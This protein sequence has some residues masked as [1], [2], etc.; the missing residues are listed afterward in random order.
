MKITITSFSDL[1]IDN[2][3]HLLYKGITIDRWWGKTLYHYDNQKNTL[4]C[5]HFSLFGLLGQ[6]FG[7]KKHYNN[8][9]LT[10][11]L[12]KNIT[13]IKNKN[14]ESITKNEALKA[15]SNLQTARNKY[16]I[17]TSGPDMKRLIPG[18]KHEMNQQY[19]KGGLHPDDHDREGHTVLMKACKF[20]D[21]DLATK[22]LEDGANINAKETRYGYSAIHYAIGSKNI[23]LVKLLIRKG[24]DLSSEDRHNRSNGFDKLLLHYLVIA[25]SS[26]VKDEEKEEWFLLLNETLKA[27]PES[28]KNK[29]LNSL[30]SQACAFANKKVVEML[31]A[32][33]AE[34]NPKEPHRTLPILTAI[35][36]GNIK[37]IEWLIGKGASLKF[38]RTKREDS[39]INLAIDKFGVK[40]EA[41]CIQLLE[42][43]VKNGENI[44]EKA[45]ENITPPIF[46][47]IMTGNENIIKW[48][49][50]HGANLHVIEQEGYDALSFAKKYSSPAIVKIIQDSY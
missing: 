18:I 36:E 30:M 6:L 40:K 19:L 1:S 3:N 43:L 47:A 50:E 4:S 44:N 49:I 5:R 37:F 13:S 10:D 39:P 8:E 38:N 15:L 7:Y 14:E 24:A 29:I 12:K 27:I 11:Y 2:N 23:E 28:D 22:I 32:H 33:G 26:N 16:F 35:S 41:T 45:Q 21:L 25:N 34:L 20:G 9:Q 31:I 17:E 48:F 42:L 46:N